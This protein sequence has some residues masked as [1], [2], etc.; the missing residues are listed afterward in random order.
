MKKIE[1]STQI[2]PGFTVTDWNALRQMLIKDF[3]KDGLSESWIRAQQVFEARISNRFF[4]PLEKIIATDQKRGEGFAV[5]SI[6]CLLL[7]HLASWRYGLIFILKKNDDEQL[8]PYEYNNSAGL[9]KDFLTQE[10]PFKNYFYSRNHAYEFYANVR[11]GLLHEARTKQAWIIRHDSRRADLIWND[12][13]KK[14]I[15]INRHAFYAGLRN[16]IN[17][18][19]LPSFEMV[20]SGDGSGEKNEASKRNAMIARVN[21]IRKMDDICDEKP[22]IV[23]YFAYGSN[24][25]AKQMEDRLVGWYFK[26]IG[27]AVLK[28]YVFTFNKVSKRDNTGKA[29][30]CPEK[31][32]CV[33]G[34]VYEME[35]TALQV[36]GNFEGGYE[37]QELNA[38]N[39]VGKEETAFSAKAF[40]ATPNP[41]E[42]SPSEKYVNDIRKGMIERNFPADYIEQ[43]CGAVEND[44]I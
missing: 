10:E 13:E 30:I 29:N 1:P 32:A 23:R 16:W 8:Y 20:L 43:V 6:F 28:G 2:A 35:E 44:P 5:M 15:V 3:D 31:D 39:F 36:L 22:E 17:D 19:F 14:S 37:L 21:F 9:F 41:E 26:P 4:S 25:L 12:T 24:I 42:R 33:L 7:E 34:T 40:I 27:T 11:C 38:L 18:Y